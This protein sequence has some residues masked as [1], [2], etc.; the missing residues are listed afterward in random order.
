MIW[1]ND[2]LA[3]YDLFSTNEKETPPVLPLFRGPTGDREK[4]VFKT[5]HL[6]EILRD[7]TSQKPFALDMWILRRHAP[8]MRWK[9]LL[10]EHSMHATYALKCLS[11]TKT[12]LCLP[13]SKAL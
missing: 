3:H 5:T 11:H 1:R 2:V 13:P 8:S 6:D 10:W 9:N 12:F 7:L 4:F